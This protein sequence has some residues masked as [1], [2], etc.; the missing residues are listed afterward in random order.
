MTKFSFTLVGHAEKKVLPAVVAL[1]PGTG[2]SAPIE[3]IR[4]LRTLASA[5]KTKYGRKEFSVMAYP[6]AG[7]AVVARRNIKD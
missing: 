3:R 1:K 2:L 6:I 7:I 5:E 4:Y